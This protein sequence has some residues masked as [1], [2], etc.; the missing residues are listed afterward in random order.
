[1][2]QSKSLSSSA[3]ASYRNI[4][5]TNDER[6]GTSAVALCKSTAQKLRETEVQERCERKSLI[7]ARAYRR[8]W[9]EL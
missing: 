4:S 9:N 5:S 6:N 1:M 8:K 3:A 7:A 2:D